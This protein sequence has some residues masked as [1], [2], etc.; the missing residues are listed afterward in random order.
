MRDKVLRPWILAETDWLIIFGHC[1]CQ[2]GCGEV[3]THISALLFSID[4]TVRIRQTVTGTAAYWKLP[5]EM[6]KIEYSMLADIDFTS[7]KT[8]KK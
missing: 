1:D 3:C 4:A 8:L 5:S 6:K 7:V 2:A